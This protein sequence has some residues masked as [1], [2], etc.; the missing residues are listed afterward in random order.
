MA[1]DEVDMELLQNM[2]VILNPGFSENDDRTP[3]SPIRT[4]LYPSASFDD[5]DSYN[6]EHMTFS[7]KMSIFFQGNTIKRTIWVKVF[8]EDSAYFWTF[9]S[10]IY[11]NKTRVIGILCNS[12]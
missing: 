2:H 5:D 11:K 10:F 4:N 3:L 1:Q 9:V 7:R 6:M 8:P 12:N